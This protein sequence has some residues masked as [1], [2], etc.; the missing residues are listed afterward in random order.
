MA[1]CPV[2]KIDSN[3]T[4]LAFA[5]EECLQTLP[6]TPVWYEQEPNSFSDFG[7]DNT[8][9]ARE[10]ISVSRQRKK[11]TITDLDA[12]GG[13]NTD[14]TQNNMTRLLQ[15]FFFADAREKYS[16]LP[17]NGT[18]L[19]ITGFAPTGPT[20][21]VSGTNID[22]NFRVGQIVKLSGFANSA[23]NVMCEI[24]STGVSGEITI[25]TIDGADL[26]TETPTTSAAVTVCGE[27][28]SSAEIAMVGN[29]VTLVDATVDFTFRGLTVGEWV[30]VGGD[31]N[32]FTTNAPGYARISKIE[33]TTLTF[34]EVTWSSPADETAAG[35]VDLY[36][37]TV[38]KN[39]E[40]LA[41]I[42]RRSYNLERQLG[43]DGNGTQSEYLV[44]AVPNELTLNIPQADKLNSDLSFV[45]L[46]HETRDGTT[47]V[48][49]GTRVSA[50]GEDAFNTSS[51]VYRMR[52]NIA[53][54]TDS[55]S[56]PLFAYVNEADLSINNNV[57]VDKA[58]G[59][60]AGFDTT[61]GNF[62][63]GGSI[64]A[65]FS[66]VAAVQAVRANSDVQFNMICAQQN[67]GIVFDIPLLAL[68]GGRLNVEKDNPIR[69]PLEQMAAEND[70]GYTLMMCSFP[71]LPT[72]AM[73]TA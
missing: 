35:D 33:A 12:S 39:E 21:I 17:I 47:G 26:V 34:S 38:L 6:T 58:I 14:F 9:M 64:T 41:L 5:E 50:E 10:P 13:W 67:A 7:G 20:A 22:V 1:T 23:N 43:S 52:L 32:K 36:F 24:T 63:V 15:G 19:V 53:D 2:N 30:F 8:L 65:Y 46:D 49:S 18:Q 66:T 60:I 54:P 57:T 42:K 59:V 62:E 71:Y 11:G 44:G 69:I 31:T 28:L 73:P 48:K 16:T 4:G 56:D 72:V 3:V 25:L 27:T 70:E 29:V 61:A 37:G 55:T 51:D 40:T 68:G 45:A